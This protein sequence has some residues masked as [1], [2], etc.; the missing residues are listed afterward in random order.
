MATGHTVPCRQVVGWLVV[1][2]A[3]VVYNTGCT[4]CEWQRPLWT[5]LPPSV[6]VRAYVQGVRYLSDSSR[7]MGT[8]CAAALATVLPAFSASRKTRVVH[9]LAS[10]ALLSSRCAYCDT[11]RESCRAIVLTAARS[12]CARP[13]MSRRSSSTAPMSSAPAGAGGDSSRVSSASCTARDSTRHTAPT[14]TAVTSTAGH[15]WCC[16]PLHTAPND[17]PHGPDHPCRIVCSGPYLLQKL[18]DCR[19]HPRARVDRGVLH[20]LL[21]FTC[22]GRVVG[23][24]PVR[25]DKRVQHSH[26][27]LEHLLSWMQYEASADL[28][29]CPA[30]NSVPSEHHTVLHA[31]RCSGGWRLHAGHVLQPRS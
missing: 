26:L 29:Y 13:S 17:V 15:H 5:A 7:S 3:G 6:A 16:H 9:A 8:R 4:P 21:P 20:L 31:L 10:A 24:S 23:R 30:R 27:I 1:A 18:H 14:T 12:D 28:V 11:R 19:R 25:T 2:G 22:L